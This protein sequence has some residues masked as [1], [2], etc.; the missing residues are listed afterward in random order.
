MDLSKI[1]KVVGTGVMA[2]AGEQIMSGA[3]SEW[4]KKVP[5]SAAKDWVLQDKRIWDQLPPEWQIK[6][7]KWGPNLG[8]CDWLTAEW[9]IVQG[10]SANPAV[11]SLFL[12]WPAAS[13]WLQK[14]IEDLKAQ[15]LPSAI[16]TK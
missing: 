9:L 7:R 1:G 12:N 10:R 16:L 15:I 11:C 5:F 8:R 2:V 14:N 13:K 6:L 4:I 3:L